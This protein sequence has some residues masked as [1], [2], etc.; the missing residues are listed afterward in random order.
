[1]RESAG[2]GGVPGGPWQEI[3]KIPPK[4]STNFEEMQEEWRL[5]RT[6]VSRCESGPAGD[7]PSVGRFAKRGPVSFSD[8]GDRR[9]WPAHPDGTQPWNAS[10]RSSTRT[11]KLANV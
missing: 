1:M 8:Y 6:D 3:L 11:T 9:C 7:E 10:F 5:V 4:F 2:V